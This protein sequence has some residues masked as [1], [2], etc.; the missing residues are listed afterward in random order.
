[1]LIELEAL[2]NRSR[3]I[4]AIACKLSACIQL[5]LACLFLDFGVAVACIPQNEKLLELLDED[6]VA[7]IFV[8]NP[9]AVLKS[10]EEIASSN[11]EWE[12]LESLI[13][14]DDTGLITRDEYLNVIELRNKL[15]DVLREISSISLIIHSF[16]ERQLR[17][18]VVID[19]TD[20]PIRL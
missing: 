4:Y 20:E 17:F 14:N 16:E 5:C 15:S 19:A 10:I 18:S 8:S 6:I 2:P 13:C 1:M 11:D 7:A 3:L 9:T 12:A